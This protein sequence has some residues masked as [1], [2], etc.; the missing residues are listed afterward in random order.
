MRPTDWERNSPNFCAYLISVVCF[1]RLWYGRR[2]AANSFPAL[3]NA[4]DQALLRWPQRMPDLTP[5]DCLLWRYVKDSFSAASTTGSTRAVKTNYRCHLRYRSW[6]AA[7]G[8]GGNGLSAGSLPWNKGR[9]HS[10]PTKYAK[11]KFRFSLSF[12][13]SPN[14]TFYAIQVYRFY[15]LSQGIMNNPVYIIIII[16]IMFIDC[17]WVDTRWQWSYNMLHV[18]GQWRLII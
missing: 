2:Q 6:H 12:C 3:P 17:K 11:I 14:A 4:A 18:H 8:M 15:N 13:R 10:A 1:R 7:A 5:C 9:T 16:I